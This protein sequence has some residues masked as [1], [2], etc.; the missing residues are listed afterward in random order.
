MPATPAGPTRSSSEYIGAL[1]ASHERLSGLVRPLGPEQIRSTSY[2]A[3]WSIAQVLSHLGSQAEIFAEIL[4]AG[5]KGDTPPGPESFPA[6]WSTWDARDPEAQVR[7]SLAA[8]EA[9]VDRLES[10]SDDQLAGFHVD[11]FG[12]SL[13]AGSLLGMRISEHAIHTWDVAVA[14]DP[15]VEL[16][17]DAVTLIIDGLDRMVARVGKSQGRTFRLPIETSAPERRFDLEVA[18]GGVE[19]GTS[20]AT[21]RDPL[22]L[23]AASLIR[24]VYGRLDDEHGGRITVPSPDVSI[25]DL[26][27]VFPG[28]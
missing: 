21:A 12:M 24:L 10:L 17:P 11:L 9:F 22:E 13:D 16:S 8:N 23:P 7:D 20:E 15:T 14:L 28:V 18:E 3:E 25:D 6:V 1:R 5:L 27:A 4:L 19:L 2:D 26:R